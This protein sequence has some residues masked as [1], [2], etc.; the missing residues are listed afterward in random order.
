MLMNAYHR[1]TVCLLH[2]MECLK[3]NIAKIERLHN[4][5]I[6]FICGLKLTEHFTELRNK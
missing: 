3:F 2:L 5:Q 4:N 1:R 6:Y